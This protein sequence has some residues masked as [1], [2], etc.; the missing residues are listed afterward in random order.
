[1]V[2]KL[3]YGEALEA[4][5]GLVSGAVAPAVAGLAGI[6]SSI[7]NLDASKGADTTRDVQD[8]LTYEP[9]SKNAQMALHVLGLPGEYLAKGANAAG[10]WT[11]EK[12][13]SPL[14]GS[15][16][17][18]AINAVPLA[19]GTKL[20]GMKASVFEKAVPVGAP[21]KAMAQA[22]LKTANESGESL[23][24]HQYVPLDASATVHQMPLS[25]YH[26][27]LVKEAG[28]DALDQLEVSE[29]A[30]TFHPSTGKGFSTSGEQLTPSNWSKLADKDGKVYVSSADENKVYALTKDVKD[31]ATLHS[32]LSKVA[33]KVEADEKVAAANRAGFKVP[34][35]N[36]GI[37][38]RTMETIGGKKE[39]AR[40]YSEYN[41]PVV[42]E[43][44]RR[45]AGLA[46]DEDINLDTLSAAR[47]T[48]A[49]PY[50]EVA[51]AVEGAPY[52][53]VPPRPGTGPG[54]SIPAEVTTPGMTITPEFRAKVG[55][56][57]DR[58][59]AKIAEDPEA[60]KSLEPSLKLLDSALRKSEM[61]PEF[62]VDRI[63][64]LRS[65]A[66]K[67]F[68]SR[69]AST[70]EKARTQLEL[71]NNIEALVEQNLKEKGDIGALTRFREARTKI[72]K[73]YDVEKATLATGEVVPK[74]LANARHKGTKISGEL[75]EIAD[76]ARDFPE[77]AQVPSR[78]PT[79]AINPVDLGMAVLGH[80]IN[81]AGWA[82]KVWAGSRAPARA[83]IKSDW[84]QKALKAE[85]KLGEK[86][87]KASQ[88]EGV[89]PGLESLGLSEHRK[90]LLRQLLEEGAP[91]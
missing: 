57:A 44:A 37:V 66:K 3:P 43:K 77:A 11:A 64:Q 42:Q 17:N 49:A 73:T 7:Y 80:T 20:P 18:T 48:H 51:K 59:R 9:Q 39:L 82:S 53:E 86:L 8:A 83:I 62:V 26:E 54:T 2:P 24:G 16:V 5:A 12:T 14:V 89:I 45:E 25:K 71:A 69:T 31:D 22:L 30:H 28:R 46:P 40:E 67:G 19:L 84:Y 36:T 35:G 63:T 79:T 90:E 10:E 47:D 81:P 15:M 21:N 91:Q 23:Y 34:S 56:E 50:R 52:T 38:N 32:T 6:G 70:V 65:D 74:A 88:Q 55:G 85:P 61:N 41:Q 76:L 4:G 60:F 68:E 29:Y 72:A 13:G 58:V 27:Q 87:L 1:M 33:D 75:G 78:A